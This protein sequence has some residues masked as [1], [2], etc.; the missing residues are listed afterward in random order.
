MASSPWTP[1]QAVE[2]RALQERLV[3]IAN[4]CHLMVADYAETLEDSRQCLTALGRVLVAKGH[5]TENEW[6]AAQQEVEL[7]ER[8]EFTLND[9][10]QTAL[11]MIRDIVRDAGKERA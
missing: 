8:A 5:I 1:E 4:I 3:A 11:E 6:L 2:I 9:E 7:G 10:I